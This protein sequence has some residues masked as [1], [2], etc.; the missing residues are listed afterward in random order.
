MSNR[1]QAWEWVAYG[2]NPHDP[3]DEEFGYWY[4]D[5]YSAD[6]KRDRL[7]TVPVIG[8]KPGPRIWTFR[9]GNTTEVEATEVT[10][11]DDPSQVWVRSDS[12]YIG[13]MNELARDV[14]MQTFEWDGNE[15]DL[16][17]GLIPDPEYL[18]HYPWRPTDY[19]S[20][21]FATLEDYTRMWGSIPDDQHRG[22]PGQ[23]TLAEIESIVRG[24][25]TTQ[26]VDACR[27]GRLEFIEEHFGSE[28]MEWADEHGE[29][30]HVE[31]YVVLVRH[32]SDGAYQR[33]SASDIQNACQ[34]YFS[35]YNDDDGHTTVTGVMHYD[36]GSRINYDRFQKVLGRRMA[37]MRRV[38][39]VG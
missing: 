21:Y 11:S 33:I 35:G 15:L 36:L 20:G 29:S 5:T 24:I 6:W 3:D 12:H 16:D 27:A 1:P 10:L 13:S 14:S 22:L 37:S 25:M 2:Q 38:G 9:D 23:P 32:T 39:I 17:W 34:D 18:V 19:R 4:F 30:A 8:R 26:R 31:A 7:A 28:W